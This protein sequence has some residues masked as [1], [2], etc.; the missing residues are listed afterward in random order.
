MK[1]S[2]PIRNF[3]LPRFVR[4]IVEFWNDAE[5]AFPFVQD[6]F[7]DFGPDC[8][9]DGDDLGGDP[10]EWLRAG[11]SLFGQFFRGDGVTY[12]CADGQEVEVPDDDDDDSRIDATYL[13]DSSAY[14]FLIRLKE[15]RVEIRSAV[16]RD[17][18]GDCCIEE[19][20]D[21]GFFEEKMVRFIESLMT[22]PP[23]ISQN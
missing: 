14:G 10:L 6:G 22:V 9:D 18:T 1:K 5:V 21:A 2:V 15:E 12:D 7:A 16:L 19:V 8:L 3:D 20:V 11:H 13:D 23:D 17:I 4:T